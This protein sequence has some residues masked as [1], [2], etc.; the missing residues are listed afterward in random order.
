MRCYHTAKISDHREHPVQFVAPLLS[1]TLQVLDVNLRY[2]L[3]FPSSYGLGL[4]RFGSINLRLQRLS[5]GLKVRF[6]SHSIRERDIG[7]DAFLAHAEAE[8]D[9]IGASWVGERRTTA[10]EEIL[11]AHSKNCPWREKPYVRGNRTKPD[12]NHR[13]TFTVKTA[14]D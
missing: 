14:K 8:V 3:H 6:W 5:V 1:S 13:I 4:A 12:R 7:Y 11:M 9:E 2:R 10:Y